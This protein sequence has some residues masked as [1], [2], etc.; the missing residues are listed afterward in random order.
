MDYLK[1]ERNELRMNSKNKN[2]GDLPNV[3]HEFKRGYR[4]KIFLVKDEKDD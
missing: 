3:I 4:H 1:Y 2:I